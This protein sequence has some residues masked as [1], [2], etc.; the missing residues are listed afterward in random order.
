MLK[1]TVGISLFSTICLLSGLALPSAARAAAPDYS[2][3]VQIGS[4][5]VVDLTRSVCGFQVD[6]AAKSAATATA[7]LNAIK[8][9]V[10]SDVRTL[11]LIDENPSLML[12]AAQNYCAARESGISEQQYMEA[13]YKELMS[14]MSE[15]ALMNGNNSNSEQ[16]RQYET[17]LMANGIAT[18]LAPK[19][20]C[21]NVTRR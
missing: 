15:P 4:R 9:L 17:A 7:Y 21:P 3:Y 14:T 11:S 5:P 18:E 20:F 1:R 16:M 13:Q 6:K 12:A 2:C 19:H 10:G 8:K